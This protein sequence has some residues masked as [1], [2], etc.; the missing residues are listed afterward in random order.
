[1]VR[2]GL[3]EKVIHSRLD[4]YYLY[5]PSL[6]VRSYCT[7]PDWLGQED[8]AGERVHAHRHC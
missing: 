7:S 2:W 5:C 3:G 4:L 8:L 6:P 1:M